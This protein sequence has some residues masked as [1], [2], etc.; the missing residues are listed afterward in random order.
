MERG[1]PTKAAV[2]GMRRTA[3]A[4]KIKSND[5]R[6]QATAV[7][8]LLICRARLGRGDFGGLISSALNDYRDDPDWFKQTFPKRDMVEAKDLASMVEVIKDAKRREV[9]QQL[10]A[11]VDVVL[12]R[13]ARNK[14]QFNSLLELDNY[15][16]SSLRKFE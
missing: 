6:V 3:M 8:V 5:D 12:A 7:A 2:R 11:A 16:V 13:V 10:I 4:L 14:T 1:S 15:F 9:Y